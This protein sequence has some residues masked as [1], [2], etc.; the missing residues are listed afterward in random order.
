MFWFFG[1][2]AY[3]IFNPWPEMEPMPPALDG[4]VLTTGQPGKFLE[5]F[6]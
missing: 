6:F 4:Q 1:W 2:E 5:F 3:G